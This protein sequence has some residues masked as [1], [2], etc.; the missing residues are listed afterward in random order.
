MGRDTLAVSRSTDT[1][2]TGWLRVR[3]AYA[4]ATGDRLSVIPYADHPVGDSMTTGANRWTYDGLGR[5]VTEQG[6]GRDS[7]VY[8]VAG[9]VVKRFKLTPGGT[10]VPVYDTLKYDAMNRL[11]E[12]V[13]AARSYAADNT[14]LVA[15]FPYY[16]RSG[17]TIP[18]DTATFAYDAAGN[19]VRAVNGYASVV[20][21]YSSDGV[22][23]SDNLRI[24]TYGDPGTTAGAGYG[25]TYRLGY[26]YTRDRRRTMVA[27]PSVLGGG[28][29]RYTYAATSGLLSTVTG[30][31]NEVYTFTYDANGQLSGRT[32]AGGS[33]TLTRDL[34]GLVTRRTI[35]GAGVRHL[36]ETLAYDHRGKVV[37]ETGSSA[38]MAYTGLGHLRRMSHNSGI[39]SRLTVETFQPNGLGLVLRDSTSL[40]TN[41]RH[42]DVTV[43]ASSYGPGGRLTGKTQQWVSLAG[44]ATPANWKGLTFSRRFDAA[45]GDLLAENREREVWGATGP[46]GLPPFTHT[47]DRIHESRSYYS[48][49]GKLRVHQTNR[50]RREGIQ[51]TPHLDTL[52]G[53]YEVYWYDALGRRVLKRSIQKN[54]ELCDTSHARCH[55]TIE[56]YVWDGDRLH[57]EVRGPGAS[58]AAAG[59]T[60]GRQAG[61]IIHVHAGGVDAPLGMV[62]NRVPYALHANWRGLYSFAT[63]STGAKAE[64][65]TVEWPANNRRAFLG[66]EANNQEW[67]WFGS[68]VSSG[69]DASGLLYRRNRYYDPLSGQ[70]TQQDPIGIAGGLN[71]YGFADGDPVNYSDPFGLCPPCIGFLVGAWA[72]VEI[73][74]AAYDAYNAVRTVFS[75]DAS[76][77]EKFVTVGLAAASIPLPGGGYTTIGKR[78]ADDIAKSAAALDKGGL[79]KAGRAWTKHAQGQRPGSRSFPSL[80]GDDATKNRVAMRF[81]KGILNDP[82]SEI[83]SVAGGFKIYAP[84]GRGIHYTSDGRF[85]TF[86]ERE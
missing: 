80:Y 70:F 53:V 59:G 55:D 44:H 54:G 74:S 12:R 62:R 56:R 67:T 36:S 71:L 11:V 77:R 41:A 7:V 60:A 61:K 13:T 68:L 65:R 4:A 46:G 8:D 21:T 20:R 64:A 34:D 37:R 72:V 42:G 84:S 31:G 66:A 40:A 47:S 79:N 78:L 9:N 14:A 49:D 58:N 82:G 27:H 52:D 2:E 25:P 1:A 57:A 23:G 5:V 69:T 85:I 76:T 33:E 50:A 24:R 18:A 35:T 10:A 73:G 51:T 86:V 16:S 45:T 63:G 48:A 30:P 22:V 6:A 38:S 3:T 19:L 32:F 39:P 75:D 26:S 28:N 15:P 29:T 17:L 81:V 83:V 43:H